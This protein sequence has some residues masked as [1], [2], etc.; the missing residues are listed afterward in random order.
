MHIFIKCSLGLTVSVVLKWWLT[1]E[2][3]EYAPSSHGKP[4]GH[5]KQEGFNCIGSEFK[6]LFGQKIK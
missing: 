4:R 2:F 3:C 5:W 6:I 1:L